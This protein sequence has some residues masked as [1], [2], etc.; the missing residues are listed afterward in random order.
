MEGIERRLVELNEILLKMA[1][2]RNGTVDPKLIEQAQLSIAGGVSTGA[3]NDTVII[4]NQ[5]TDN[6][7]CP[8][9]P[10]GPPGPIGETGPKGD[11]GE[12]GPPGEAGPEGPPGPRGPKGPKGDPGECECTCKTVLVDDDYDVQQDDCYIGVNAEIPTTITLPI[13]VSNGTMIIVKSE[14]GPPVGNRKVKIVVEDGS[15]IDG[16]ASITLQS[17][18]ECLYVIYRDGWHVISQD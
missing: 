14:M 10:E 17:P 11:Q 15:D 13:N 4:N 3:G 6:C 1:T 5:E 18:Y 16:T 9:G 12:Q 2:S 8:P 7:N